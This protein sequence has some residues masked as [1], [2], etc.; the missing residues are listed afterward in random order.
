MIPSMSMVTSTVKAQ[1]RGSFMSINSCVQQL[2]A[3]T[4]SF[5]SGVVITKAADGQLLNYE[6]VGYMAILFSLVSVFIAQKLR[7]VEENPKIAA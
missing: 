1:N 6:W 3:G 5:I 7:P 4:A 2:S